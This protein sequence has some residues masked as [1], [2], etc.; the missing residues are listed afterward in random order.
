MTSERREIGF[1]D[2][3]EA[4]RPYLNLDNPLGALDNDVRLK[5]DGIESNVTSHRAYQNRKKWRRGFSQC[6]V[7][8]GKLMAILTRGYSLKKIEASLQKRHPEIRQ[9]GRF[10]KNVIREVTGAGIFDNYILE[11]ELWPLRQPL[12]APPDLEL[13]LRCKSF[14]QA[15]NGEHLITM[16]RKMDRALAGEGPARELIGHVIRRVRRR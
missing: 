1:G 12:L 10:T 4:L 5:I 2:V 15:E 13:L 11:W 14:L 8:Q 7:C 6:P 9:I 3:R 16:D